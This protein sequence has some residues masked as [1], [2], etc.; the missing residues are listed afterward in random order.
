[1]SGKPREKNGTEKGFTLLELLVVMAIV[2]VMA[3]LVTPSI[4]HS[5][6]NLQLRTVTREVSA[7]LRYARS[8]AVSEKQRVV[9]FFD[10]DRRKM[11]LAREN[12]LLTE[13]GTPTETQG[14][15]RRKIYQLPGEIRLEEV[16][17]GGEERNSGP[18]HFLFFANGSSTGG[19]F[20]LTNGKGRHRVSIDFITG[21]VRVGDPVDS[22]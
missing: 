22:V 12:E 3:A 16:V 8:L 21:I 18:F 11:V 17:V 14:P 4:G 10:E 1:M 20:V 9:V 19:E 7:S 6:G 13:E 2:G 5:L 15:G